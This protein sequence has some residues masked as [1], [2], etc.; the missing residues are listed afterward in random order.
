MAT[1]VLGFIELIWTCDSCGTKNP[2]PIKSCT[3]CGAPQPLNVQFEKVDTGSFDFIKDQALI[4]M[5]QIGA[6]KHCPYCGTRNLTDTATC[7]KCGSDITVGSQ[8][9]EASRIIENPQPKIIPATRQPAKLPTGVLVFIVIA[10]LALCVFGGIYFSKLNRTEQ[11]TGTVSAI[12]WH[13]TVE[14]LA[15]RQ[16]ET[17]DWEDQIPSG[18]QHYDCDLRH[19]YD[20][21]V[22]VPNSREVCGEPY[23]VDTGTGIGRVQQ[24]CVYQVYENYCSYQTMTW[25]LLDTLAADGSDLQ[26]YWP[27][28]QLSSSEK[29]GA[30]HERYTI[31]FTANGSSYQ[32]T[33]SDYDLYQRAYPGSAWLLDINSFG[34][35]R[36]ASPQP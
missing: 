26:A 1:K 20:S 35:I 2:G 27:Q 16:V 22:E 10:V 14:V 30:T 12:N 7:V 24:D 34:D 4:R 31:V 19:R 21:Q 9:R 6:D 29:Y 25:T 17:S 32:M 18:V 23:T 33:T 8:T 5:A 15:Y 11:I 3:A 28:A 36:S 13:R